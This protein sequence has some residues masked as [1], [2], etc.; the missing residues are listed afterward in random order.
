ME[1]LVVVS[2]IGILTAMAAMRW[3][4]GGRGDFG[5]Q[6]AARRLALN[7]LHARR[8]TVATGDNHFVQF[9]MQSGKAVGFQLYR[10]ASG[11]DETADAY[12]A[13]PSDFTVTVSHTEAEFDFEGQALAAYQIT[14][15]GP[16]RTWQVDVA[17]L[18]GG[19]KVS[20][21]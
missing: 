1:L 12:Y 2:L 4:T 20:E 16:H 18:S 14:L 8:A 17:V 3:G 7:L 21:P 11:G 10:A 13:F 19:I 5:S 6:A 9:D 15:A